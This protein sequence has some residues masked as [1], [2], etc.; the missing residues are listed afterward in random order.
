MNFFHKE[1]K[2]K[3]NCGERGG[4]RVSDLF[5]RNLNQKKILG[6]GG[7]A[8]TRV[9]DFLQRVGKKSLRNRLN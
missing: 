1:S 4:A 3:K 7:D 2:S 6:E 5:T 9:S 8:G